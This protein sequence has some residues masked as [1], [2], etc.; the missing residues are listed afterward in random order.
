MDRIETRDRPIYPDCRKDIPV[1]GITNTKYPCPHC[2]ILYEVDIELV[3]IF[4]TMKKR[5]RVDK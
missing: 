1:P 4:T 2:G 3:Q 5:P